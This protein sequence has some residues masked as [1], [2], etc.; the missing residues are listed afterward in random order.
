MALL[1]ARTSQMVL[2]GNKA[3]CT[4]VHGALQGLCTHPGGDLLQSLH[5][6][7]VCS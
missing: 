1:E 4:D 5:A 2:G 6:G 3:Q 7:L